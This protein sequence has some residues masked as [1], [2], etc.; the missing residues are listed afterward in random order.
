MTL[1]DLLKNRQP[2]PREFYRRPTL[3]VARELL[4]TYLVRRHPRGTAAGMIVETEAYI[5]QDDPACHAARGYT[6]RTA[7]MF[8]PPGTAYIYFIY[9]MYYCLNAV[10]EPEGFPAAVLIRA[11]EPL[12]GTALMAERRGGVNHQNLTNGPGKLCQAFGLNK[13]QN[14]L[15]LCRSDL[16]IYPG[17][18][19]AEQ[20][21]CRGPRVGI[22]NG[23]EKPWRFWI[24]NS[25]FVSNHR[26][27][28]GRS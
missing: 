12:I 22:R 14:G 28:P 17:E 13:E 27:L 25:R 6:P 4:G 7:V 1:D 16:M 20:N 10:T 21:I 3:E 24:A 11:V 23:Q 2:L 9:G 26:K 5:G 19:I 18:I 15:D 8:G